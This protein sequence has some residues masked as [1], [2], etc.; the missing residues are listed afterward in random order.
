MTHSGRSLRWFDNNC[1]GGGEEGPTL[2]MKVTDDVWMLMET[3]LGMIHR[4]NLCSDIAADQVNREIAT[5]YLK[6][7]METRC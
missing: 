2:Q 4:S 7:M 3:A 1:D 5:M 6:M